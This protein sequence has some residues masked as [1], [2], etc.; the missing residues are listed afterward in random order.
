MRMMAAAANA[1]GRRHTANRFRRHRHGIVHLHLHLKGFLGLQRHRAPACVHMCAREEKYMAEKWPKILG[2]IVGKCNANHVCE[3]G[4]IGRCESLDSIEPSLLDWR[5]P[6]HAGDRC[7]VGGI[8]GVG[9]GNHLRAAVEGERGLG[10]SG[11]QEMQRV[12]FHG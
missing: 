3:T 8:A 12:G 2:K 9:L 1:L 7:A 10:P 6:S 11:S 4:P 5:H